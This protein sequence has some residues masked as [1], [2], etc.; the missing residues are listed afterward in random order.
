M[1]SEFLVVYDYDTGGVWAFVLAESEE[2]IQE[3]MPELR[4][5]S[6]R[7]AWLNDEE[8][9]LIRERMTVEITDF[10]HPFLAALIRGRSNAD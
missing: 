6:R 2:Q 10:D 5:V 9:R 1:S 8:E 7:P 3:L 4:V